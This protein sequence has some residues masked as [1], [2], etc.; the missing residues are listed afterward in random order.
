MTDSC[1]S[2][3]TA[4]FCLTLLGSAACYDEASIT[5]PSGRPRAAF[6]VTTPV[7]T[8]NFSAPVGSEWSSQSI[9]TAPL[10]EKFLGEF[11]NDSVSLKLSGLA[12]H[13]SIAA[14]VTLYVIRSWD[15]VD[16]VWG[17]PDGFRLRGDGLTL[18]LTSFG[19][20]GQDQN[21]PFVL[22]TTVV[23]GGT[24][25]VFTNSLGY[26]YW[27][28]NELIDATYTAL[29]TFPHTASTMELA[30]IAFGLQ[31]ITDE[32][33]GIDDVTISIVVIQ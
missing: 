20:N 5:G 15:G 11:N 9:A 24:G 26:T 21:F 16:P 1:V 2:I 3:R 30:F 7:Y 13:D 27:S 22:G 19:N 28:S 32:S 8:A 4:V 31:N 33:W 25:A 23:P 18:G 29:F 6:N 10:G 14:L 12:A 17:G